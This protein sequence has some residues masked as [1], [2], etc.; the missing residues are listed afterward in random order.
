MN[1]ILILFAHPAFER[2]RV[3]KQLIKAAGEVPGVTIND[4]YEQYPD[5]DIDVKREQELLLQHDVIIFQHPIYWYSSPAI[6]KQWQDLVLEHGWAYGR[7]GVALAGKVLMNVLSTGGPEAAYSPAGNNKFF[8]NTFLSPFGQ[9]AR[10]CKMTYWPPFVVH[11]THRLEVEDIKGRAEEY[12]QLL[13]MIT[14]G[15]IDQYCL[16]NV[17]YLNQVFTLAPHNA[18]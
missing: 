2:S 6:I 11:G 15:K 5:F 8:L 3:Q 9:T 1:K 17:Y 14:E 10:T 7:D 13:T 16:D 4:L 12:A 18:G